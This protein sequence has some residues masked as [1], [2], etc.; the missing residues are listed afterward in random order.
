MSTETNSVCGS[1]YRVMVHATFAVK[2]F[3]G[4]V[5]R[6]GYI[7]RGSDPSRLLELKMCADWNLFLFHVVVTT[8]LMNDV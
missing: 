5:G 2:P 7:L 1:T 3:I 6:E 8:L 4:G